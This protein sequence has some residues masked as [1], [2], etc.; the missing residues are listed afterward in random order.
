V[1]KAIDAISSPDFFLSV[2][3]IGKPSRPIPLRTLRTDLA[4]W[5]KG[6][7]YD[8]VRAAWEADQEL[9]TFC[10]NEHDVI[11][12]ISP[13]RRGNSRGE[14]GGRAIG[15]YTMPPTRVEPH[16]AISSAVTSKVGRY[17]KPGLPYIVAVNA[18]A[19]HA[20][21][22]NAIDALFGTPG[23][24]VRHTADGLKSEETRA[25]DGAWHNRA[26]P[27]NTR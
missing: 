1:Y 23:V 20:R 2:E 3:T 4:R 5:L 18:M 25:F 14:T 7:D 15:A 6:L 21:K 22:V 12:T 10:Y 24:T 16:K 8:Q 13:I 17:G 19:G 27:V 9:P 26:G 11:L